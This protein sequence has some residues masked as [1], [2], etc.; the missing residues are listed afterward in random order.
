MDSIEW[1]LFSSSELLYNIELPQAEKFDIESFRLMIESMDVR[2][3]EI[4]VELKAF[5]NG[6][7]QSTLYIKVKNVLPAG[8]KILYNGKL[9][10]NLIKVAVNKGLSEF[11][12]SDYT[13]QNNILWNLSIN[14]EVIKNVVLGP[15]ETLSLNMYN[16]LK[17]ITLGQQFTLRATYAEGQTKVIL[18]PQ[19][20]EELSV[21][22]KEYDTNKVYNDGETVFIDSMD[23]GA[24]FELIGLGDEDITWKLHYGNNQ[25]ATYTLVADVQ[26]IIATF[27]IMMDKMEVQDE[28]AIF[29]LEAWND[30]ILQGMVYIEVANELPMG[31][32][33][34]YNEAF[35]STYIP[36]SPTNPEAKFRLASYL[37]KNVEW[38]LS[39]NDELA[40]NSKLDFDTSFSLNMND[41]K[42]DVDHGSEFIL[43]IK[44]DKMEFEVIL[45]PIKDAD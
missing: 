33:V 4:P 10:T 28:K 38:S 13:G 25:T 22:I 5:F 42:E 17:E 34:L 6:K 43:N 9:Y 41:Y 19:V 30:N 45:L 15:G 7:L 24:T 12:L 2:E 39:I 35:Y 8:P 26:F 1:K 3:D 14:N 36:V 16:H 44:T 18:I 40:K 29:K 37:S 31:P 27:R 32:K 11:K 20:P 21:A 23:E